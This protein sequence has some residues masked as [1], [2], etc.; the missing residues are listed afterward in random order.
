MAFAQLVAQLVSLHICGSHLFVEGIGVHPERRQLR[1]KLP[2]QHLHLTIGIVKHLARS[3]SVCHQFLVSLLVLLGLCKL[4]A[5][6]GYLLLLLRFLTLIYAFHCFCLLYLQPQLCG[7]DESY[8]LVPSHSV[9]L[10]DIEH[11]QGSRLLGIDSSLS[12]FKYSRCVIFAFFVPA[13]IKHKCY[14][15]HRNNFFHISDISYCYSPI[16]I[17]RS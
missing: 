12:G 4:P 8:L 3:G 11:Q 14:T 5:S 1:I 7:V 9:T 2:L 17:F 10:L 13:G 15:C 6:Y 16:V